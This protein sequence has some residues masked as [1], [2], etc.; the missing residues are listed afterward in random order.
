M[1]IKKEKVRYLSLK[2]D[3]IDIHSLEF[4]IYYYFLVYFYHISTN[5]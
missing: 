1:K 4:G 3:K 2:I 5:P